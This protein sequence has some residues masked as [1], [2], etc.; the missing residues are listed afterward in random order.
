MAASVPESGRE[1]IRRSPAA[2]PSGRGAGTGCRT[3][4]HQSVLR[5][6]LAR[7]PLTTLSAVEA[8]SILEAVQL[9]AAIAA[10]VP[11]VRQA[12]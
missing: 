3:R 9:Q 8:T 10:M 1:D 6:A 2:A 12:A 11:E 7:A 4:E 5:I